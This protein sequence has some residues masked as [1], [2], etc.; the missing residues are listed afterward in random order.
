MQ[1]TLVQ[2][3]G[4]SLA[5]VYNLTVSFKLIDIKAKKVVFEGTSSARASFE[6]FSAIYANVRARE[7]AENRAAKT[8]AEDLKTRVATYL[9]GAA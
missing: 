1:S 6:R 7:D 4:D 2:V 3:D 9:S 5:L 8:I